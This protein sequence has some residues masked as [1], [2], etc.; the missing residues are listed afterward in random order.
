VKALLQAALDGDTTAIARL[1]SLSETASADAQTIQKVLF[2]RTGHAH[3]ICITGPAG[4]GKSTLISKLATCLAPTT[5]GKVAIIACDP[6]SPVS[7]GAL[8]GDRIR[9]H[10][11]GSDKR[12]F[13]RSL[14]SRESRGSLPLA[15]FRAADIFD[16]CGYGSIIIETL[17][18]GQNQLDAMQAAHTIIALSAPGLG[19]EI[20]AMKSGLLEV[21]HIHAITKND[22]TGAKRTLLDI[23][24]A[25]HL[26]QKDSAGG[27]P[28]SA[29]V[30]AV[31][32]LSGEGVDDLQQ[33]IQAHFNF[34]QHGNRFEQRCR[35]M[36][37][38]RIYREA[39]A[40][41]ELS[42][43]STPE[44]LIADTIEAAVARK[45]TPAEAARDILK[46]KV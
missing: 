44:Q 35:Q 7:G 29:P 43:S 15:V 9:M 45:L 18:S 6:S 16:A 31:N 1:L 14:A 20:Q 10:E 30:L 28:W 40:Y 4:A 33:T 13:I 37:R 34:L 26:R 46:S 5:T 12:C 8:L 27:D 22:L 21:A 41:L 3:I 38:A 19:D 17:G 39:V 23:K 25:L 11:L 24:N 2:P 42:F 36:L 32:G